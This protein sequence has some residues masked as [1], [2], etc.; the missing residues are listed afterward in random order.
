M[1]THISRIL[2]A[3]EGALIGFPLGLIMLQFMPM[4]IAS[5]VGSRDAIFAVPLLLLILAS[6]VA[7]IFVIRKFCLGGAEGLRSISRIWL[8]LCAAGAV[9]T[10]TGTAAIFIDLP[11]NGHSWVAVRLAAYGVPLLIPLVH[12]LLEVFLRKE[13]AH[14]A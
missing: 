3:I 6:F 2:L 10:L 9:M 11:A 4:F 1:P 5:A 7:A 8:W 13:I 12:V 14:A